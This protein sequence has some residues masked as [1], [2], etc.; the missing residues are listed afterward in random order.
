[1]MRRALFLIAILGLILAACGGGKEEAPATPT[2]SGSPAATVSSQA[3]SFQTADGVTIR[4]HLFGDG[5]KLVILCHMRPS[6][7]TSWYGFADELAKAGYSALTFDFRGYGESTGRKDL[8]H[9]D[10]DIEAAIE[11]MRSEGYEP[12][13][14]VGASMGGTASLIAAAQMEVAGVVA[15]SAPAKF[16]GLDAEAVVGQ[17][18]ERK[19]FIASKGD[20][21]ATTSL[22]RLFERAPEPKEEEVFEGSDHGTNLLEGKYAAEVKAAIMAFLSGQ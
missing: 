19:L 17:V 11:E 12:I 4:G 5:E 7:Q 20:S 18:S 10:R 21:S 22:E 13:Y 1:M 6:D 15:I 3:V 2:V 8:P 14:L 16:E 9:I